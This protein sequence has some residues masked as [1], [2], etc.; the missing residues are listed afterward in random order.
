MHAGQPSL[1]L[2]T[3]EA[4][5]HF[6][7][8]SLPALFRDA[9]HTPR[10]VYLNTAGIP[11]RDPLSTIDIPLVIWRR[12]QAWTPRSTSLAIE[13]LHT[14]L[15]KGLDPVDAFHQITSQ[16]N[17]LTTCS[18]SATIA[19]RRAYRTWGTQRHARTHRSGEPLHYLDRDEPK[20]LIARHMRE[21][22]E[23]PAQRVLAIVAYAEPGNRVADLGDQ[24]RREL[25]RQGEKLF[26]IKQRLLTFPELRHQLHIDLPSLME[27]D[28]Q[29]EPGERIHHLLRRHAPT[30]RGRTRRVLWL[31]WGVC[32]K[33]LEQAALHK[34]QL[35]AWLRFC[36]QH[37]AASCPDD[38]RIITYIALE[39][40]KPEKVERILD[41]Q[42]DEPWALHAAFA[43]DKLRP[44]RVNKSHLLKYLRN[45]TDCDANIHL[46]LAALL[47]EATNGDLPALSSSSI[48]RPRA[49]PG[50][51]W[52]AS[53]AAS[54]AST[55]S[56]TPMMTTSSNPEPSPCLPC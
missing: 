25:R 40:K 16:G 50:T 45:H 6:P 42:L 1:L 17:R 43:I 14:W 13:W 23:S 8:D 49:E 12:T 52:S 30:V 21:L 5:E 55:R 2:G 28:L 20:A 31:D 32:G 56:P 53:C 10:L 47:L 35:C 7:I 51:I 37:L 48:P 38:I 27:Q 24:L 33:G 11:L 15:S 54:W 41:A 36:S 9:G 4:Q 44:T 18:D 39:T 3:P 26:A 19:L 29:R 46:E 22:A 34:S